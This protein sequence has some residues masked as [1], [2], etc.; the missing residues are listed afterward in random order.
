MVDTG[1]I[2]NALSVAVVGYMT[3]LGSGAVALVIVSAMAVFTG[4]HLAMAVAD[5][6]W[7]P[8]VSTLNGY[9]AR[10]RGERRGLR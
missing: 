6:V 10:A 9:A 7:L 5:A 1:G 3:A 8:L 2:G 4:A